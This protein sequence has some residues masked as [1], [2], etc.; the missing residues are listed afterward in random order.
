MFRHLMSRLLGETLLLV[1]QLS[2]CSALPETA[3]KSFPARNSPR[4]ER[5]QHRSRRFSS[6]I[7]KCNLLLPRSIATSASTSLPRNN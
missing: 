2:A 6:A 4:Q 5:V 1:S 7:A 3:P